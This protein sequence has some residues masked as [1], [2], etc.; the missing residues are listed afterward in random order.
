M[1]TK[2][3]KFEFELELPVNK[4]PLDH[5]ITQKLMDYIKLPEVTGWDMNEV[6]DDGTLENIFHHIYQKH[7]KKDE[8]TR[9][10]GELVNEDQAPTYNKIVK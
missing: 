10:M 3:Y 6:K 1:K 9:P 8:S 4:H 7:M 5:Y 2:T